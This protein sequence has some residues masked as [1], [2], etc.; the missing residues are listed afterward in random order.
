MGLDSS[1]NS[2]LL[3]LDRSVWTATSATRRSVCTRLAFFEIKSSAKILSSAVGLQITFQGSWSSLWGGFSGSSDRIGLDGLRISDEKQSRLSQHRDDRQEKIIQLLSL[4]ASAPRKNFLFFVELFFKCHLTL[5]LVRKRLKI[6]D[7]A[8]K[9]SRKLFIKK[10]KKR[11]W[12][13]CLYYIYFSSFVLFLDNVQS[14]ECL[15]L[16]S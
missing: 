13:F 11:Y 3:A 6:V 14:W 5:F 15:G 9:C 2:R 1:W 7:R 16:S 10:K 12:Y 8:A 4:Y